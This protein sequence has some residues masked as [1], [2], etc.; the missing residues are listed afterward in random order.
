M[1]FDIPC[2]Y[3]IDN[4]VVPCGWHEVEVAEERSD[5][6]IRVEKIY[7]AKTPPRLL[8]KLAVPPLRILGFSTICYSRQG[9]PKPD[10]NP[11]VM[12][13]VR[14][15]SGEEQ[16]LESSGERKNCKTLSDFFG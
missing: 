16:L 10:R 3:L 14:T 4:N 2:V 11:V 7:A 1:T 8:K 13:S 5:R 9:S 15:N 12:I 6:A